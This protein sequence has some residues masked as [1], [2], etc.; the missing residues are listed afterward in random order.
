M[1]IIP[2]TPPSA[3]QADDFSRSL[4]RASRPCGALFFIPLSDLE[5]ASQGSSGLVE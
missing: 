3:Q 2:N 1:S 5:V 4:R